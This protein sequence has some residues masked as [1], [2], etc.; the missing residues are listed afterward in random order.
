V[1]KFT[2]FEEPKINPL[3]VTNAPDCNPCE[4][5]LAET[6]TLLSA[7]TV[8]FVTESFGELSDVVKLTSLLLKASPLKFVANAFT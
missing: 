1:A 5:I 8:A 2:V 4:R 6:F 7:F 3:L